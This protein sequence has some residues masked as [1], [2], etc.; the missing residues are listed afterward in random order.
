M[1]E[2]HNVHD[3]LSH[4]DATRPPQLNQTVCG[5]H[6]GLGNGSA[7]EGDDGSKDGDGGS[8]VAG[9]EDS[10]IRDD[11]VSFSG[12]TALDASF[13]G[14]IPTSVPSEYL[15]EH[16]ARIERFV[17]AVDGFQQLTGVDI[18]SH[19]LG[20]SGFFDDYDADSMRPEPSSDV[21]SVVTSDARSVRPISPGPGIGHWVE[22][23]PEEYHFVVRP[24]RLTPQHRYCRGLVASHLVLRDEETFLVR[25][26]TLHVDGHLQEA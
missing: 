1:F 7:Q 3:D 9:S 19:F 16:R 17:N 8:T 18:S 23:V 4:P 14:H 24:L 5:C 12:D 15:A 25:E 13:E 11:Y 22:E 26:N 21:H 6:C 2:H 10:D 20:Q